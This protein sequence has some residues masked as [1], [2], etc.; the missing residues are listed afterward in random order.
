MHGCALT[1][2]DSCIMKHKP[3]ASIAVMLWTTSSLRICW[4]MGSCS[5]LAFIHTQAEANAS[6]LTVKLKGVCRVLCCKL[7]E[8]N[9]PCTSAHT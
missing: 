2:S 6:E 9:Q 3:K 7:D 1:T 8:E 4:P 5:P